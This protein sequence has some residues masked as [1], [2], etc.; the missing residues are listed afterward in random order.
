MPRFAANLGWLFT[1]RPFLD[2]FAAARAAGFAAVEFP[3]PYGHAASEIAARLDGE[4]LD[5]VL[6]NLPMGDRAKG[7]FGI[8]C[9]PEHAADFPAGVDLAL[10]YAAA[11]RPSRV[12]IIAG[13][14]RPGEDRAA[15][16]QLLVDHVGLA[17]ERFKAAGIPMLLEPL[18]DRDTPGFLLPRQDD[19]ARIVE[20]FGPDALGLQCDL[21]HVAMMGDDA[22]TIL[23][24][25]YGI[26]RHVQF[27]DA[28]GRGE[29]GTGAVPLERQFDLLERLGY[30]G[31]VSAEYRPSR[32]TEDTLGWMP[33][34]RQA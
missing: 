17:V 23:A 11:L 12:N 22:S 33:R 2:R 9:R 10:E 16:E 27:A 3:S 14:A 32:R 34:V 19:G 26:I 28:P 13:V 25:H 5:C 29:P 21:Y 7:E 8:A 20:R 31:W 30:R 24:R 18:N 6:F 1:E 4:G 15:L